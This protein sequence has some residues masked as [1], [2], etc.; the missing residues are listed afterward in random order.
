MAK[1]QE[2]RPWFVS[3]P[4]QRA[5]TAE[6]IRRLDAALAIYP[7]GVADDALRRHLRGGVAPAALAERVRPRVWRTGRHHTV[8]PSRWLPLEAAMTTDRWQYVEGFRIAATDTGDGWTAAWAVHENGRLHAHHRGARWIGWPL[9]ALA[10]TLVTG[11]LALRGVRPFAPHVPMVVR[12]AAALELED[13]L[14][15]IVVRSG[16]PL[17]SRRELKE[18]A[19]RAASRRD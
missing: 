8:H 19:V 7:R 3:P 10:A 4:R 12:A 5:R 1:R 18:L 9:D 2:L 15:L 17:A 6:F 13:A 14:P 11:H 16:A